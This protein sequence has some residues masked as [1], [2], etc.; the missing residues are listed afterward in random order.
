MLACVH[1]SGRGYIVCGDEK[2][3]IWT[4]HAANLQKNGYQTGKPIPPTD[5]GVS[6]VCQCMNYSFCG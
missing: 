2:G 1:F 6:P 5:V 4:Y 3:R